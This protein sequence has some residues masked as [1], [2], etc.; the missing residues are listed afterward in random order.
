MRPARYATLA[1]AWLRPNS[2]W[3][4]VVVLPYCRYFLVVLDQAQPTADTYLAWLLAA[5]APGIWLGHCARDACVWPLALLVPHY[6]RTLS[7]F[8]VVGICIALALSAVAAQL[9][10]L[11]PWG[12]VVYGSLTIALALLA[13]YY[14]RYIAL[15]VLAIMGFVLAFVIRDAGRMFDPAFV[16]PLAVRG[17]AALLSTVL[18]TYFLYS[19]RRLRNEDPWRLPYKL[20]QVNTAIGIFRSDGVVPPPWRVVGTLSVAAIV[21][22]AM[23]HYGP[24]LLHSI[25]WIILVGALVLAN[26]A[27]QSSSFPQGKLVAATNL[28]LLGAGP[29]RAAVARQIMWRAAGDSCLGAATFVAVTLALGAQVQLYEVFVAL[30]ACHLY[31][32]GASGFKWLLS[33]SASILVAMP[34]IAFLAW[35]SGKLLSISL[36][37]AIV[38]FAASAAAAV[39]WGS[40][41]MGRLDFVG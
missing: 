41:R 37:A 39:C 17:L 3:P 11:A 34:C 10:G 21:V 13:G 15:A 24:I 36:P 40:K 5:G 28:L 19:I 20:R 14:L 32:L 22:A 4:L 2:L 31:L 6:T 27:G 9:G 12:S 35:L 26:F 29:T 33:S 1:V 7:S 16:Q 18:L 25:E 38:T 8:V 30:A 23:S